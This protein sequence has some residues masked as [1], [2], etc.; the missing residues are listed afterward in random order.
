MEK[1]WLTVRDGEAGPILFSIPLGDRTISLGRGDEC[2]VVF[3]SR[4]I[5]RVH[6]TL[7]AV[8]GEISFKDAGSSCG[9][10]IEGKRVEKGLLR[11]GVAL[12]F[13]NYA[14]SLQSS[15]PDAERRRGQSPLGAGDKGQSFDWAP[16]QHFWDKL[17]SLEEPRELLNGLLLGLVEIFKAQRGF[18]LL[19]EGKNTLRPVATHRINNAERFVAISKT[20]YT[21]ALKSGDVVFVENT[22]TDDWYLE[23][24]SQSLQDA[25]RSIICRPLTAG[26]ETFGVIYIDSKEKLVS[27]ELPLFETVTDM[28]AEM[29]RS[30]QT[31]TK[32]L[33]A[34]ERVGAMNSLLKQDEMYI[35]GHSEASRQL[36]SVLSLT[37]SQD[38]AILIT[39]E[40]GTGKEIVA[41]SIHERSNR[42]RG[43]FVPVNCA[44]LPREIIE[45][46]LFGAEKGAYTGA[47]ERRIGRFELASNGTLFLDEIGEL[48]PD[49]QVKLLRVIQEKT[50]TRLGSGQSIPLDFRLLCAT[51]RDLEEAVREGS[52][53]QDFYF[54]INVFAVHLEPLRN[55]REDI[56]ALAD[57]FLRLFCRRL[58]KKLS[59]IDEEAKKTLLS[60]NWPGNIRELKNAIERAVVL[61]RTDVLQACN[62]PMGLGQPLSPVKSSPS[63]WLPTTM[64]AKYD[65]A[66]AAF[67][68]LFI[69]EGLAQHGGVAELAKSAGITRST[70]YRKMAK[71]GMDPEG[72]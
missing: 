49:I 38:V 41:R 50:V 12:C 29:V 7:E 24:N 63:S 17:R 62:L 34:Q 53:R 70:I 8:D 30:N 47:M 52:F 31:R 37:A 65:D 2:D 15:L 40:T 54:R 48:A 4:R 67:D 18:V 20:V 9:L 56:L 35:A 43:P 42:A 13:A 23:A 28:A 58:G 64:P 46:E 14:V 59:H 51:N 21:R 22:L 60:H 33:E 44:A 3:P 25:P 27:E 45:A 5:S 11:E 16:F 19:K 39:G 32:L 55:R 69:E 1:K 71:L 26:G 66:K 10:S 72:Y 61:E 57:H 6:L 68:R 36:E